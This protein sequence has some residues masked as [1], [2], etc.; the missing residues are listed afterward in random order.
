MD[1]LI[2]EVIR[3]TNCSW[4]KADWALKKCGGDVRAA[5]DFIRNEEAYGSA[6]EI[7]DKLLSSEVAYRAE[8]SRGGALLASFPL[9]VLII[10]LA[11][12]VLIPY[13]VFIILLAVIIA[14][15]TKCEFKFEYII[16]SDRVGTVDKTNQQGVW[17]SKT[18]QRDEAKRQKE[19]QRQE[20]KRRKHT[21]K[22]KNYPY[23]AAPYLDY[24]TEDDEEVIVSK[25]GMR[26]Q[27]ER[28]ESPDVK[29][30]VAEKKEKIEIIQDDDGY[31]E[32]IIK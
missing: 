29:P 13:S 12:M 26:R 2:E 27:D 23:D 15:V 21:A 11:V 1:K 30:V 4:Q 5:I 17:T 18:Q 16:K 25:R 20:K 8:I 24:G 19:M 3:E 9:W 14:V 31:N 28:K 32:I 22:H 10:L 6:K 7:F